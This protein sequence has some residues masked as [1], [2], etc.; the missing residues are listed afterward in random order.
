MQTIHIKTN[1]YNNYFTNFNLDNENS[2]LYVFFIYNYNSCVIRSYRLPNIN[3]ADVSL[4]DVD[5]VSEYKFNFTKSH[6]WQGSLYYN[7][8]LYV[9]YGGELEKERGFYI[10]DLSKQKVT[11]IDFSSKFASQ[12][13][14]ALSIYKHYLI[15]NT[16]GDGIYYLYHLKE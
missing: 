8:T 2:L 10:L 1:K 14:E 11:D 6:I 3:V 15:V 7:N 12:E 13:P 5:M 9:L 16:N 4:T